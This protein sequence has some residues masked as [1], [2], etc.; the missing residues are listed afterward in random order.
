MKNNKT[1]INYIYY[2]YI[3][4]KIDII[5]KYSD[6]IK[7]ILKLIFFLEF[8]ICFKTI[9]KINLYQI[10]FKRYFLSIKELYFV[11]YIIVIKFLTKCI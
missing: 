6:H 10:I 1:L 7:Y 8:P 9:E 3:S 5:K 2:Y 11:I 4:P